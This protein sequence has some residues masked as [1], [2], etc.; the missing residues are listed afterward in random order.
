MKELIEDSIIPNKK[1]RN[2]LHSNSNLM[3]FFRGAFGKS[4][5]TTVSFISDPFKES[6]S[7]KFLDLHMKL[8][9]VEQEGLRDEI[10]EP[11]ILRDFLKYKIPN[12]EEMIRLQQ[13]I[14]LAFDSINSQGGMT[15][16]SSEMQ[17]TKFYYLRAFYAHLFLL[18]EENHAFFASIEPDYIEMAV[19]NL[20]EGFKSEIIPMH[21]GLFIKILNFYRAKNPQIFYQAL[22]RNNVLSGLLLNVDNELVRDFIVKVVVGE[23]GGFESNPQVRGIWWQYLASVGFFED[24]F[25]MMAYSYTGIKEDKIGALYHQASNLIVIDNLKK[26]PSSSEG[27]ANLLENDIDWLERFE[28]EK[29]NM[30]EE[31]SEPSVK[32]KTPS[33]KPPSEHSLPPIVSPRK[34]YT[35]EE[36]KEARIR[37]IREQIEKKKRD[38]IKIERVP[39][40]VKEI[41]YKSPEKK[42]V[43]Q[44]SFMDPEERTF[45]SNL[46][47]AFEQIFI[48]TKESLYDISKN[49]DLSGKVK[50]KSKKLRRKLYTGLGNSAASKATDQDDE[51][52]KNSLVSKAPPQLGNI[53]PLSLAK[54]PE[55]SSQGGDNPSTS[56]L[57]SPS[58]SKTGSPLALSR[59]PKKTSHF[60]LNLIPQ[61]QAQGQVGLSSSRSAEKEKS[62]QKDR[63]SQLFLQADL[64]RDGLIKARRIYDQP[65]VKTEEYHLAR[66]KLSD[67]IFHEESLKDMEYLSLGAACLLHEIFTPILGS[68]EH[69]T[70]LSDPSEITSQNPFSLP[71]RSYPLASFCECMFGED[72]ET[73]QDRMEALMLT[74]LTRYPYSVRYNNPFHSG[75][76]ALQVLTKILPSL[77]KNQAMHP[78]MYSLS[79]VMLKYSYYLDKMI[80]GVFEYFHHGQEKGGFALSDGPVVMKITEQRRLL[81][82]FFSGVLESARGQRRHWVWNLNPRLLDIITTWVREQFH[83]SLIALTFIKGLESALKALLNDMLIDVFIRLNFL[84]FIASTLEKVTAFSDGRNRHEDMKVYLK[85]I[86]EILLKYQHEKNLEQ[87][88]SIVTKTG[89]WKKMLA[90]LE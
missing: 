71:Q 5:A 43:K 35:F 28:H 21:A 49:I 12:T 72:T 14:A 10:F 34:P 46:G 24:C 73:Q 4:L 56:N 80:H 32:E 70:S 87:F 1:N 3:S 31:K 23:D 7:S 42:M 59:G 63:N 20:V 13:V 61:T 78:L 30:P 52:L 54:V 45:L 9:S 47:T 79:P 8:E 90:L 75:G 11:V 88:Y 37:E 65:A 81:L 25:H 2:S 69:E 29:A 17:H 84:G 76:Q 19:E 40:P 74:I 38:A 53:L 44:G 86:T 22:I 36:K 15:L 48:R 64:A 89:I 83:N 55:T 18:N 50:K 51:S 77:T 85:M 82:D 67:P 68:L 58:L 26:I 39:T 62:K 66:D 60:N 16:D 33:E 6:I 41:V 27:H 57:G